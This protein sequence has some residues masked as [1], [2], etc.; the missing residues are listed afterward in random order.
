MSRTFV[1]L[2]IAVLLL[3]GPGL[4]VAQDGPELSQTFDDG[5]LRIRYPDGWSASFNEEEGVIRLTSTDGLEDADLFS[6]PPGE[7]GVFIT[8]PIYANSQNSFLLAPD[9][10]PVFAVGFVTGILGY[11]TAFQSSSDDGLTQEPLFDAV[12]LDIFFAND[13]PGAIVEVVLGPPGSLIV[14]A[15]EFGD[16]AVIILASAPPDE[17]EFWRGVLFRM[18]ITLEYAGS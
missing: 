13:N 4:A 12:D 7:V 16:E 15:M 5:Q 18:L 10:D 6:I 3:A 11:L 17:M 2:L 9:S 1:S 8:A 14:G